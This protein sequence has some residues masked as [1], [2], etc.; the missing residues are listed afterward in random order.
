MQK[1]TGQ[2]TAFKDH[3]SRVLGAAATVLA[4]AQAAAQQAT[5]AA[6][7]ARALRNP[8]WDS[9]QSVRAATDQLDRTCASLQQAQQN[10]NCPA[11][12][13]TANQVVDAATTLEAALRAAPQRADEAKRTISSLSARIEAARTRLENVPPALSCL[14]K[15]FAAASS[16]D[17]VNNHEQATQH[18][19]R[20]A[21]LLT[22]AHTTTP[23][24][25]LELAK[26]IRGTL[27]QAEQLIDAVPGRLQ[28]LRDVRTDPRKQAEHVRFTLHDA[29]MFAVTHN[30]TNQWGTVLDAQHQ[31]IETLE[32]ALKVIHPDYWAYTTGLDQVNAFIT[33]VVAKMRGAVK[34]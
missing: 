20:A 28:A 25:A 13:T 15:E 34:R 26:Q 9:Y 32:A 17:L 22:R 11:I 6:A 8:Q 24:E 27:T 30:L 12:I 4:N 16:N 19:N 7:Q 21:E 14:F 3:N 29:Q 5:T 23:D 18:I 31:R 33:S 1:V 2:I 10:N